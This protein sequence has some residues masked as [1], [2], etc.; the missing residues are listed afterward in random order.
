M[1]F[2]G[3]KD[4]E[5]RSR[6]QDA[7]EERCEAQLRE[8]GLALTDPGVVRQ[9]PERD[10]QRTVKKGECGHDHRASCDRTHGDQRHASV[11]GLR[12]QRHCEPRQAQGG[13]QEKIRADDVLESVVV[14]REVVHESAVGI[15]E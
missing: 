7:R 6:Y 11:R 2:S 10:A 8:Q 1:W 5:H 13:E 9:I 12:C 4:H 15:G 3:G 14:L